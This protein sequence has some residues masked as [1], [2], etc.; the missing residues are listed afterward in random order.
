MYVAIEKGHPLPWVAEQGFRSTRQTLEAGFWGWP[1]RYQNRPPGLVKTFEIFAREFP[2]GEVR[3]GENAASKKRLPYVVF[4]KPVTLLYENF[5]HDAFGQ[6]PADWTV[7][8]GGA[9]VVDIPDYDAEM[10]PT[11]FDLS[12]VPRYVPLDLRGLKLESGAAPGRRVSRTS[13]RRSR[14]R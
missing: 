9:T 6:A 12:T 7:A 5:R 13:I 14:R 2:A 3:L 1:Y 4:V 10:R 11:S 8:T